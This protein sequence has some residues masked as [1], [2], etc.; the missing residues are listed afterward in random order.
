MHWSLNLLISNWRSSLHS[1][2]KLR[3]LSL[4]HVDQYKFTTDK[5]DWCNW[6]KFKAASCSFQS[7]CA[8]S[9]DRPMNPGQNQP[10]PTSMPNCNFKQICHHL[11][12]ASRR[13]AYQH[14]E[15]FSQ[16]IFLSTYSTAS[17]V[18]FFYQVENFW[19]SKGPHVTWLEKCKAQ[20]FSTQATHMK[21]SLTEPG[22]WS[23]NSQI[24][25]EFDFGQV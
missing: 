4:W 5:A 24:N 8:I 16:P 11:P 12:N 9:T 19:D 13:V 6:C 15:T 21:R 2:L 14:T 17:E 1:I 3:K 23:L 7:P 25:Q 18:P 10:I 22:I 20:P